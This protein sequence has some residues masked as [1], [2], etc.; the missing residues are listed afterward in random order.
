MKAKELE[1]YIRE[2]HPKNKRGT[3]GN[4]SEFAR[5]VGVSPQVVHNWIVNDN[6]PS[7]LDVMIHLIESNKKL[8]AMMV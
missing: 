3:V 8:E 2:N 1:K 6:V 4:N 7:W 5:V